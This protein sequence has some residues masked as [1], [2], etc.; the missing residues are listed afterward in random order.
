MRLLDALLRPLASLPPGTR[1][2]VEA[3]EDVGE[4]LRTLGFAVGDAATMPERTAAWG[5]I[6]GPFETVRESAPRLRARLAPGAW[7][8][9]V[10]LGNGGATDLVGA[11][12]DA[13]Y[14]LA[15]MPEAVHGGDQAG[16]HV[17]GHHVIGHHVIVRRVDPGVVA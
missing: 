8:S 12:E 16:Q 15:Q 2:L 11:M 5:V 13:G 9:V 1:L 6:V 4:A 3:T 17:I 10:A 7:L 14:A